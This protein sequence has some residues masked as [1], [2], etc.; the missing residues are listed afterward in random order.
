[1]SALGA[2]VSCFGFFGDGFV[3]QSQLRCVGV[4]LLCVAQV[5]LW[6][7]PVVFRS[8]AVLMCAAQMGFS[9]SRGFLQFLLLFFMFFAPLSRKWGNVRVPN[10]TKHLSR[11][12]SVDR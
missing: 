9:E 5:V 10:Q 11:S 1:M 6:R 8:V 4:S 2:L 7:S 3:P 12:K